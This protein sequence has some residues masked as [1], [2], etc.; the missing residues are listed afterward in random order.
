MA[1][2][3]QYFIEHSGQITA[4]YSVAIV[5]LGLLVLGGAVGG[6]QRERAFDP[7]VGWALGSLCFTLSGVFLQ[8]SF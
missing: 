6:A 1:D 3:I 4:I 7:L 8:A 5:W 2:Y